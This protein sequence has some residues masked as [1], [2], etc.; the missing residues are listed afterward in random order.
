MNLTVRCVPAF[1]DN[2]IWLVGAPGSRRVAI[3]D[4]GDA[5]PVLAALE[6]DALEPGAILITHHHADHIG[7]VAELLSRFDVPVYGPADIRITTVSRPVG[8]GAT[9][10][11]ADGISLRVME[12]PGHTRT[13]VCYTAP[14]ALFCGDT[15]FT[16]GCGRLFE[17]TPQQMHASL[18]KIATLPD[19]TLVYCA[20]EYTLANLAFAA[21]AEPG[22]TAIS[23]RRRAAEA[24]RAAG[25]PTVPSTLREERQTNP[26]LRYNEPALVVAAE[27]FAGRHLRPGAEVL[28][29]VRH[30]KDTLD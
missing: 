7:G 8:E 9:V 28:G 19:S 15:L 16:G 24:L 20:H 6:R 29:V 26:F 12:T 17:G 18:E 3:V 21:V 27:Q 2:Y 30:W 13:H 14:G 4:P 1:E 25:H 23:A 10:E 5:D 11:L 22:N